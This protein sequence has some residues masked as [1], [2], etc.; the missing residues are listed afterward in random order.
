MISIAIS[1]ILFIIVL[2]LILEV[3]YRGYKIRDL[4]S[5]SY[6]ARSESKNRKLE[7]EIIEIKKYLDKSIDDLDLT[8]IALGIKL[9]EIKITHVKNPTDSSINDRSQVL[10]HA[11]KDLK[12]QVSVKANLAKESN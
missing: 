4:T 12:R 6:L 10:F 8:A 7:A 1:V 11:I 3:E 2:F 9:G 5:T